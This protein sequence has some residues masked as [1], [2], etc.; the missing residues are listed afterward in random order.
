M[1][2]TMF[3]K[4]HTWCKQKLP[5]DQCVL[6][7]EVRHMFDE[8]KVS[9][10]VRGGVRDDCWNVQS[11]QYF[12]NLR[13]LDF[14]KAHVG[15]I[16]IERPTHN[17]NYGSI[18]PKCSL[19]ASCKSVI[20]QAQNSPSSPRGFCLWRFCAKQQHTNTAKILESLV[21]RSAIFVCL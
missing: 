19:R 10:A 14:S 5:K 9:T 8:K 11:F 6:C 7:G 13:T 21:C 4:K 18:L 20:P 3:Q 1:S 16:F 2:Q 12:G 17:F 15:L